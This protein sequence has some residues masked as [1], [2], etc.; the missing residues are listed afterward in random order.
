[1]GTTKSD[2]EMRQGDASSWGDLPENVRLTLSVAMRDGEAYR[3][4]HETWSRSMEA[5]MMAVAKATKIRSGEPRARARMRV[6]FHIHA[7]SF[8]HN[9][10][11]QSVSDRSDR[12]VGIQPMF[13]STA[14]QSDPSG[15][16][17]RARPYPPP[18]P[19]APPFLVMYIHCIQAPTTSYK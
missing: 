14:L 1:V 5:V 19:R 2:C 8:S 3:T 10:W 13:F 4:A 18:P 16:F 15:A 17:A 7:S 9:L 11:Y 12:S 6:S